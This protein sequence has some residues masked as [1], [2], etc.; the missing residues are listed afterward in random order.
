[1]RRI[2]KKKGFTNIVIQ[3]PECRG[4]ASSEQRAAL[5]KASPYPNLAN[6]KSYLCI[7]SRCTLHRMRGGRVWVQE[8]IVKEIATPRGWY[9]TYDKF[10]S[11]DAINKQLQD[12]SR[13]CS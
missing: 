12:R 11:G 6:P 7:S 10:V 3:V 2:Y 1:M 13:P 4:S 5:E 8:S 9:R